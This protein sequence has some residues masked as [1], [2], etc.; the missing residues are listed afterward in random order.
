LRSDLIDGELWIGKLSTVW[1]KCLALLGSSS[2]IMVHGKIVFQ[3][4]ELRQTHEVLLYVLHSVMWR[5]LIFAV[6][7]RTSS[8]SIINQLCARNQ[9][10]KPSALMMSSRAQGT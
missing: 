4:M 2:K 8:V 6:G 10:G 9:R 5:L 1:A 3:M 7:E